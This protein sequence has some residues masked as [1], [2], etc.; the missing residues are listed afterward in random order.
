MTE[1]GAKFKQREI[2]LVIYDDIQILSKFPFFQYISVAVVPGF[3]H[4]NTIHVHSWNL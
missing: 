4:I 2:Y 3:S 1:A